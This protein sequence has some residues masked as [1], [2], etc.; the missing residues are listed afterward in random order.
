M[1]G[2]TDQ[3]YRVWMRQLGCDVTITELVSAEAFIHGSKRTREMIDLV[4]EESPCGVQI[5]GANPN[6]LAQLAQYAETQGAAFIDLNFGC[7]VQ[8]V[9]KSGA[10]AAMMKNLELMK[11]IFITLKSCL[12]IPLS[13]KIRTGWDRE[14]INAEEI[15]AL[16]QEHHINWV[17]VHGRTRD[18]KYEGI[19]DWVF[20]RKLHEHFNIPIVGNGDIKCA[21]EAKL[22]LDQQ[23][24]SAVMIARAAL[25]NPLLFKQFKEPDFNQPI[26]ELIEKLHPLMMKYTHPKV[27]VIRFKKIVA[28]LATGFQGHAEFRKKLLHEAQDL[29]SVIQQAACFFKPETF[30]SRPNELGFLKGGHG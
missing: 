14:H 19:S 7:P 22:K 6:H 16:A 28:W 1:A 9:I 2:I 20:I 17:V 26:I 4:A 15:C 3:A 27:N 21:G 24:A 10:G 8:K 25:V 23:H 30:P 29:D 13:I 12:N 5:F 11:E 18:Q